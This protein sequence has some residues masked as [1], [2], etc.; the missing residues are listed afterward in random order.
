MCSTYRAKHGPEEL[1]AVDCPVCVHVK[2]VKQARS[3]R[4]AERD[5]HVTERAVE[6]QQVDVVLAVEEVSAVPGTRSESC[7]LTTPAPAPAPFSWRWAR[8]TPTRT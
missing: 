5:A 1:A 8:A 7:D 3:V 2:L 4:V 6:R